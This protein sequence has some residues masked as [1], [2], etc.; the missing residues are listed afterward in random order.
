MDL[1]MLLVFL[2]S[3]L[4]S[5]E[6]FPI[7]VRA[8]PH[9]PSISYSS[10]KEDEYER[11]LDTKSDSQEK[12][13]FNRIL[14]ANKD[15]SQFLLE[16]DIV[17]TRSRSAMGCPSNSCF[18]PQASD[19][20]VHV[21]YVL[22]SDYDEDKKKTIAEA[23]A[24]FETLTCIH[25]VE[26][27][28][29]KDYL[30][31]KSEKG[32]WSYYGKIGG[33]QTLSLMKQGCIWKGVIQHELDHALGFLHEH[34]RSDRDNYVK[35][36]WQYIHPSHVDNF[37]KYSDSNNLDLPYD[38]SSVMHY[39]AHTFSNTSG[40]ATIVAIPD[41]SV[42]IGK[43]NGLSNLDVAKINKL[44]KCNRCS[45]VLDKPSGSLNS[46]NYPSKY[47]DNINCVW[48]IRI[49][50]KQVFLQFEALDLQSSKDCQADYIKVYDGV[51]K[52]SK[53]LLDKTC[54]SNLP[55]NLTA[56]GT[57]MLIEFVTDSTETGTGFQASYT[58]GELSIQIGTG[59]RKRI[60]QEVINRPV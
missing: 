35:I 26:R 27:K 24:E 42:P 14:K 56:S 40:K 38:Y 60:F 17:A 37:K 22:S 3:L 39:S 57:T 59:H 29:E 50:S 5:T 43:K 41:A 21:P 30:D 19:G 51:S 4:Y 44:Y 18:W 31:I 20:I 45:T 16:G 7:P 52:S 10:E 48:L 9:N 25:F 47:S 6:A 1:K 58:S 53:V 46:L 32:C 28:T 23:M 12:A 2:L 34:T 55:V 15:S 33:A 13:V 54:G 49:P 8:I 11:E 36:M